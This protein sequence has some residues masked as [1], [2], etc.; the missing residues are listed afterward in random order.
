MKL[1][2]FKLGND[3]FGI[4]AKYVYRVLDDV[5]ITPVCLMPPFYLGLLYNRG[6]LFDVIDLGVL[7]DKDVSLQENPR[8]MVIRWE[9][10]KLAISP[11]IIQGLV[12]I[13]NDMERDALICEGGG[14]V[15]LI[16]PKQIWEKMGRQLDRSGKE[17][18]QNTAERTA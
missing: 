12:W 1:F 18:P 10:R 9:N 17:N 6:E 2:T 7:L 14:M 3:N 8:L 5:R 15:H 16:T 11:G 13:E 4:E